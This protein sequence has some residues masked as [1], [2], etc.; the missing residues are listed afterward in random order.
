M[1]LAERRKLK[2]VLQEMDQNMAVYKQHLDKN[3]STNDL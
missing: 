1:L 2:E 3:D